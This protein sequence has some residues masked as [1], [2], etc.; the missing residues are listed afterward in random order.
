M[1]KQGYDLGR[2]GHENAVKEVKYC[3]VFL[4]FWYTVLNK[5]NKLI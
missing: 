3:I 4:S 5:D 2:K 1:N